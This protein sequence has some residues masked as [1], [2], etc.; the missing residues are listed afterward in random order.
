MALLLTD[1]RGAVPAPR[2][3]DG[4][5]SP[6]DPPA[7]PPLPE[8]PVLPAVSDPVDDHG[9]VRQRTSSTS[10]PIAA[11]TLST[12]VSTRAGSLPR[13]T[14]STANLSPRRNG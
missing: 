12:T 7:L 1:R 5:A 6:V 13:T 8:T 10:S 4:A 9:L 2:S 3:P 11:T 14:T